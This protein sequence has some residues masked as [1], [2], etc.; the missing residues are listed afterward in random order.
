VT[1]G[2]CPC[3]KKV[4]VALRT[5]PQHYDGMATPASGRVS[6]ISRHGDTEPPVGDV[7]PNE[8]ICRF[9]HHNHRGITV[10]LLKSEV[11]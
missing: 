4:V 1:G 7:L 9:M 11:V 10:I 5:D 2:L 8:A 3:V 6:G